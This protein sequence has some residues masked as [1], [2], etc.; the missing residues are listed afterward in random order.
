MKIPRL[1]NNQCCPWFCEEWNE[2]HQLWLRTFCACVL[3]NL[4]PLSCFYVKPEPD[5]RTADPLFAAS[6]T[7]HTCFGGCWIPPWTPSIPTWLLWW[8]SLTEIWVFWLYFC[9]W[10]AKTR[11]FTHLCS[12]M[13]AVLLHYFSVQRTLDFKEQSDNTYTS[14]VSWGF[15]PFF[16]LW[17]QTQP[18]AAL[19]AQLCIS[20]FFFFLLMTPFPVCPI[21]LKT[22]YYAH[23]NF[24]SAC[25]SCFFIVQVIKCEGG[26]S[27]ILKVLLQCVGLSQGKLVTGW[28]GAWAR[29][30]S[31]GEGAA[32][33]TLHHKS[34]WQK[35]KS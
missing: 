21:K 23:Y 9:C 25:F 10:K 4:S 14:L 1:F 13:E 19:S 30:G 7:N 11:R 32:K 3:A 6:F 29:V 2:M 5:C 34:E 24:K 22:P 27:L 12:L 35:V 17:T 28:C 15:A 16:A 8:L 31:L 18:A 33:R 20:F 26:F